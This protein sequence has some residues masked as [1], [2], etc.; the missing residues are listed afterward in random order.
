MRAP[1][2]LRRDALIDRAVVKFAS[3]PRF[4]SGWLEGSLADGNADDFSDID[5]YLAVRDS[6]WTEVF[7]DRRAMVEKIA[8]ILASM[9]IVGI[10]G[11]AAL[12][13]GPVKLDL[14][15]E[16]ESAVGSHPRHAVKR[17]WGAEDFFARMTVG[18]PVDNASIARALESNILGFL[19]GATWPVRLLARGQIESFLF[20]AILLV[21][22]AIVPLILLER[23]PRTFQRNMFTR[24][25]MLS[26]VEHAEYERLIDRV[27]AS[28]K[29]RDFDAMRAVHIDIF[30]RICE[31]ARKGFARYGLTFPPRVEDEMVAFSNRE[32]PRLQQ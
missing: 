14:F 4:P 20:G 5:L 2:A 21:E 32:W 26:A 7:N 9:D 15:L 16:R 27:V 22:T 18:A 24:A 6:D 11:V 1:F 29:A 3:D 23:D 13:E 12:V 30:K 31:L 19:Q 10:F 17:L 8:P 28:V 25:K